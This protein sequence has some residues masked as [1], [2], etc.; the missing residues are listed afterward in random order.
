LRFVYVF[1]ERNNKKDLAKKISRNISFMT[2]ILFPKFYLNQ[3]IFFTRNKKVEE[4]MIQAKANKFLSVSYQRFSAWQSKSKYYQLKGKFLLLRYAILSKT[5]I[6]YYNKM[7]DINEITYAGVR[8][9]RQDCYCAWKVNEYSVTTLI[10]CFIFNIF[11]WN[12][13]LKYFTFFSVTSRI[14]LFELQNNN[15]DII[16]TKKYICDLFFISVSTMLLNLI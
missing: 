9:I 8:Y 11:I 5:T 16:F 6:I 13:L 7:I 2:K 14:S 1:G 10:K 12:L 15:K 4:S 3:T